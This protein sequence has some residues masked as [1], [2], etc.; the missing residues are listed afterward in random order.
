MKAIRFLK[1]LVVATLTA[2]AITLTT[3]AAFAGD[4]AQDFIDREH[5]K[6][7]Q[8]LQQPA[9]AARDASVNRTLDTMVDYD[10]LTRRAFGKPC[11]PGISACKNW[12]DTFSPEDQKELTGELKKLVEKNYR[13]N[14][15]KTL[16][17][18]ITYRGARSLDAG[19]T[20][21]ITEAK[22]R[23]KPR[24]PS[25]RV[26]YVVLPTAGK[27]YVVDIYT[28]NSSLTKNYYA[29]FNKMLLDP[30]KGLPHVKKRLIEKGNA[31]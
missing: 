22:D 14:L 3:G 25:V 7:T 31:Q 13:K 5:T 30:A 26:D 29:D 4:P 20:R 15:T 18:D 9:S 16:N 11:P 21:V 19:E 6:L 8:L 27:P 10:E 23:N 17:Y 12:W 2:G 24:E 28:E 1:G